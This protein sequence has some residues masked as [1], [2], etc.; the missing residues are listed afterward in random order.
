L[1]TVLHIHARYRERGGEDS[2][3]AAERELLAS[4]GYQVV[5][6]SRENAVNSLHAAAQLA[7]YAWNPFS[8]RAILDAAKA[9]RPNIAHVHNTWYAVSPNVLSAL[10]RTGIPTVVTVHN[11]RLMCANAQLLRNGAPCELCISGSPWQGLRHRCYRGSFAA[12]GAAAFGIQFHRLARS[13][14]SGVD[15]FIALTEFSRKRLIAAGLPAAAV[16]VH[17]NFVSD[18]GPRPDSPARSKRVLYV[19]RLSPEKGLPALIRAWRDAGPAGLELALAGDGPQRAALIEI[20]SGVDSIRFLG[21]LARPEIE[22]LLLRSRALVYPS[23]TYEGQPLAVLEAFSAGVPV[24][25]TAHGGLGETV[26]ALGN[27]WLLSGADPSTWGRA[28]ASVA[29]DELVDAGGNA[30]RRVFEDKHSP[31][32]AQHRLAR[33]YADLQSRN[34]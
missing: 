29:D 33:L 11:Y 9:V 30:A 17:P 28:F 16:V 7:S 21:P 8:T 20:A 5:T 13:W 23:S 31:S 25:G 22:S 2:V 4:N 19:G 12:S 32:V 34:R 18:P 27:Q 3:V 14:Q 6:L 24:I 26:A 1:P 10:K 15:R